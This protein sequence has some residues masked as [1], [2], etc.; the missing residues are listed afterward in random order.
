[1]KFNSPSCW[2]PAY[3]WVAGSG[4]TATGFLLV[5]APV[6]T[7]KLMGIQ[8]LPQPIAF[9]GF[10]GVFVL[11]VGLAYFYAA[12]LPLNARNA[13][14]WQTVWWL[15]A[16]IRSLVAVF[17]AWQIFSG[18][19]EKTWLTVAVTDGVLAI[20]QWTGLIRGWLDFK[21]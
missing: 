9:A 12:R 4:D 15:T 6:W 16:L 11:G 8:Q 20:F 14:R 18:R 10:V 17:I 3:Q 5:V 2:L 21:N 1:M 13:P 7:L 19:M